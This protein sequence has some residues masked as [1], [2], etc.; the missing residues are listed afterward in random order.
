MLKVFRRAF[1]VICV[2]SPMLFGGR[3]LAQI[4]P[5]V[6]QSAAHTANVSG[7]VRSASGQPV[8]C[9]QVK[10]IGP[11]QLSTACDDRGTFRFRS[12]P[13]GTYT[14]IAT[15]SQ[16][17]VSRG[18]I[19]LNADTVVTIQ[20]AAPGALRTIAEVS[21][22]GAGAHINVTST[23][24]TSLSPSAYAF[25][26]N[27][28]WL[29]LFA[30]VPGVAASGYSYGGNNSL[31]VIP[32]QPQQ[33]VVL[34]VNGALPYETATL[35]DGMPLQAVS[36]NGAPV[37]GGV[38]LANMPLNAFDTA[39]IVRG[40][41]ANA[42]SIVN[43]IGGSFVLHAPSPVDADH[44]EFSASNDPYGGIVSNA[45]LAL[46]LGRLSA[47]FVYGINDSPG[48][49]GEGSITPAY[50]YGF[51]TIGGKRVQGSTASEPSESSGIQNC[52][53]TVTSSLFMC[54]VPYPTQWTSQ[55]GAAAISYKIG[56]SIT[57]EV[58]YAG[59][60]S[61]QNELTG[62]VPVEFAPSAADPPYK[63]SYAPSPPGQT[64]YSLLGGFPPLLTNASSSL[65]EEKLTAYVGSGV[66]RF[67]AL[68]NNS[69]TYSDLDTS[70]PDGTYRLWGT[71]NVGSTSPGTPTAYNGSLENVI[72][73]PEPYNFHGW[74][75][76][77]DLLGS[78]A[79]QVGPVSSAGLSYVTSYYNAASFE[80]LP[81]IYSTVLPNATSNTTNEVR[82]H[83]DTQI[84]NKLSLG[85][86][87][88]FT[89]S[90]YPVPAPFPLKGPVSQWTDIPFRYNA[91]RL[92]LV[93]QP[94]NNIAVRFAG[95]GGYALPTL[96]ELIGE[97]LT[98]DTNFYTEVTSNHALKP[99]EAFALNLGTDV[100][101]Q[102]NTVLSFDL[103]RTNLY[104]QLF[105][106]EN[107]A[108]LNGLPFYTYEYKNLGA[109]RYEGI[110]L[111]V[112]RDVPSGYYW[113]GTLGLTRGYLVSVPPGFYNGIY[114]PPPKYLPAPCTNCYNQAILPGPN[115][116][117]ASGFLAT[118]PYASA[119]ATFGYR[120]TRGRY[121]DL[122]GTYFGNNN[123]YYQRAFIGVDA[124]GSYAITPHVALRLT[125]RNL[126]GAYDQ[127]IQELFPAYAV[128]VIPG[129]PAWSPGAA[130]KMPY[131]PRSAIFT[132]D[133]SY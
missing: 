12:V 125:L 15:S 64:T 27:G 106:T 117:T 57:A 83:F 119:S 16:G 108:E 46:H 5:G 82:V 110:N 68:Q 92:G 10:L 40:P 96:G 63:G 85:L 35:L 116:N 69:F 25:E 91:P 48:P 22:A 14:I 8:A 4:A 70:F 131:E 60:T 47:T 39:D 28:T 3:A 101:L 20:Y 1:L 6:T 87:W 62:Y 49:L 129:A 105:D 43:S 24:I 93:W 90:G 86:S 103:Y 118:V 55:N 100:R 114:Y 30:Q 115:F 128:P 124:H 98:F 72:F 123:I 23:S 32:G 56:P 38:D 76:N 120:W 79:V 109:S 73:A 58:F 78:Y 9:S 21:T 50:P 84:V 18:S 107:H 94:S 97:P 33:P 88:Y 74:S 95:G 104:G 52:Y 29:G 80:Y 53:C 54:C 13:W 36:A 111:A 77:R 7:T 133:Y 51:V 89:T 71:A 37:G 122:S 61:R 130:F 75:N 65:L 34:S 99:E 44:F 11:A 41:G 2:L 81:P 127:S 132:V 126:T 31:A 59:A 26:G 45:S 113:H 102:Q 112:A 67:A 19:V 121:F 66:L 42:P 17:T